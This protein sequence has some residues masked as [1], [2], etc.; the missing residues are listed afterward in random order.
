MTP[1]LA[2]NDEAIVRAFHHLVTGSLRNTL[3]AMNG[4]PFKRAVIIISIITL[5]RPVII[6]MLA[7]A[8]IG[9]GN[10]LYLTVI[11][12]HEV[13][14][15]GVL[16]FKI[17]FHQCYQGTDECEKKIQFPGAQKMLLSLE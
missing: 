3:E 12:L 6:E 11:T 17:V 13:I 16:N 1:W 15:S 7:H 5:L 10:A 14:G 9:Q 2:D 4:Q 8:L